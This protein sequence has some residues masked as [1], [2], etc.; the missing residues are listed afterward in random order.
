[1][2]IRCIKACYLAWKICVLRSQLNHLSACTVWQINSHITLKVTSLIWFKLNADSD[3]A[4]YDTTHFAVSTYLNVINWPLKNSGFAEFVSRAV[5]LLAGWDEILQWVIPLLYSITTLLLSLSVSLTS[6]F[7]VADCWVLVVTVLII[8]NNN[9]TV[10]T[11]RK[12]HNNTTDF[13]M[14]LNPS[15]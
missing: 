3:N 11:P 5:C 12:L 1:M 8:C 6:P 14:F 7:L 2:W 9:Y 15:W 13:Q 4:D 10:L